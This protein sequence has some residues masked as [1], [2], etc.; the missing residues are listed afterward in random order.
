[1]KL[2]KIALITCLAV[3]TWLNIILLVGI[4]ASLAE[5][6][7]IIKAVGIFI[8]FTISLPIKTAYQSME[9]IETQAKEF[10]KEKRLQLGFT[11]PVFILTALSFSSGYSIP[12]SRVLNLSFHASSQIFFPVKIFYS[13]LTSEKFSLLIFNYGRWYLHF[14]WIYLLTGLALD[15][16]EKSRE[17]LSL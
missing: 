2:E 12:L 7:S 13:Q 8:V 9:N 3:F 4:S 11:A 1:M 10:F 6:F 5:S 17:Y 15:G 14:L 16:I